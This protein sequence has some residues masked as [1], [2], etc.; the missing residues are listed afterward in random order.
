VYGNSADY[1]TGGYSGGTIWNCILVNNPGG[2]YDIS[3][4]IIYCCTTFL[5]DGYGDFGNIAANPAFVNPAVGDFRLQANSPCINA[6]NNAYAVGTSDLAG[7]PRISGGT[8]DV[9]AYEF[10]NPASVLSYA[11]LQ[12]YGLPTDGS[13]DFVDTDGDGMNNYQEWRAGTDPTNPL[14]VLKLLNQVVAGANVT[15]T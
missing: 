15:V 12:Q 8:V 3:T 14:S 10:Q 2:D 4:T 9:G 13:A 1:G 6:G 5:A 7:N 11:W